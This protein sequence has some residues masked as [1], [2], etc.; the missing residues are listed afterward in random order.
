MRRNSLS[1]HLRCFLLIGTCFLLCSG[2]YLSWVYRLTAL[3]PPAAVDRVSMVAGY[4]FQAGG[5]A[6]FAVLD[7]RWPERLSFPAYAASLALLALCSVPALRSGY[8]AGVLAFGYLCNLV[9]GFLAGFYLL[10]LS[11]TVEGRRR[12]LVFGGGYAAATVALWLVSRLGGRSFLTSGY[13]LLF[14]LAA[15]A[16]A[17]L[18]F[19]PAPAAEGAQPLS[20]KA[21]RAV[22]WAAAA[23][24]FLSLVKNIGFGFPT[25]DLLRGVDLEL[26]RVLY[27]V[28]L[29]AAGWISD[30]SRK[31][32]A[33]ATLA[34]LITP[35]IMIALR[36]EPVSVTV[37]WAL[38]YLFYGFFS[39]FRAVFFADEAEKRSA[40]WLAGLGLLAGRLGD[41]AGTGIHM[42]CARSVPVL[43]GAAAGLFLVTVFLFFR[44]YQ[45]AFLTE[46][47]EKSDRE[48]FEQFS[49]RWDLS[50]RERGVMRLVLEERS[51]AEMAQ[52]LYVS[53]ST[54]KFHI[55]NILQKTGCKSRTELLAAYHASARTDRPD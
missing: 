42:L 1:S 31:Y 30:R 49:A 53:E 6:L 32:G 27:A 54:V 12:G 45:S 40:S 18:L 7:Q 55:H 46:P 39:L 43:V 29:I 26:S 28:G 17:L 33:V 52:A 25:A 15:A 24:F 47:R 5:L 35:F 14:Y 20:P 51:N 16:A 10:S 41:A 9:I 8:V 13:V 3:L 21:R 34:A 22:L 11:V 4:L 36:G 50:P 37:F 19:R 2:I 38:D 48:I 23:M 44:L